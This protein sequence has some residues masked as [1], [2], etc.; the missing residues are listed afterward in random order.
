M[1]EEIKPMA[2]VLLVDPDTSSRELLVATLAAHGFNIVQAADR[3]EAL[4]K[5]ARRPI[6]IQ[7]L[8]TEIDLP[9]LSGLE[10]AHS[11]RV[12]QPGLRALYVSNHVDLPAT[13]A[14]I[15]ESG[16]GFL[17]KPFTTEALLFEVQELLKR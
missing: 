15:L 14:R 9:E 11:L 13:R 10:L 8:V 2:N 6:P 17:R 4:A 1:N 12:A 5:L 3:R 16:D 7:L